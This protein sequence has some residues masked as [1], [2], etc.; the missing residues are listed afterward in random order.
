MFLSRASSNEMLPFPA[1]PPI[2]SA[3]SALNL[4]MDDA[5]ESALKRASEAEAAAA[6]AADEA[7]VAAGRGAMGEAD[8]AKYARRAV[9]AAELSRPYSVTD[10]VHIVLSTVAFLVS[11]L[12]L[13]L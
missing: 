7:A 3:Q 9:A 13:T 11:R 1:T 12:S 5:V 4:H 6:A 2:C 10:Q 8:A